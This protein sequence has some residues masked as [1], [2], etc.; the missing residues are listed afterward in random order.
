MKHVQIQMNMLLSLLSLLLSSIVFAVHNPEPRTV[1]HNVRAAQQIIHGI[2][3]SADVLYMVESI[4]PTHLGHP[5]YFDDIDNLYISLLERYKIFN[6]T[7]S[8][9]KVVIEVMTRQIRQIGTRSL[10]L[11]FWNTVFE[12]WFLNTH[13]ISMDLNLFC[14]EYLRIMT[15]PPTVNTFNIIIQGINH[16]KGLIGCKY[17][18]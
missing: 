18:F 4:I 17:I 8:N 15:P 13:S 5:Q 6:D 12:I 9:L 3:S 14:L 11:R 2:T 7:F 16:N 10:S 1:T